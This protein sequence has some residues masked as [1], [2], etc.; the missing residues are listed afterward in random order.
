MLPGV[1]D[2]SMLNGGRGRSK[3]PGVRDNLILPGGGGRSILTG[4][5]DRLCY[6]E[7]RTDIC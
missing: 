6:L 1:G 3:L 5:R 7:F 4:G 2:R